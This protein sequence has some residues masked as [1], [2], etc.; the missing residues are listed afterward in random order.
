MLTIGVVAVP[1][2]ASGRKLSNTVCDPLVSRK[3]SVYW[4][5]F[6]SGRLQKLLIKAVAAVIQSAVV[7]VGNP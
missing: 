4:I 1:S 2:G 5:T 7:P 3:R 6:R